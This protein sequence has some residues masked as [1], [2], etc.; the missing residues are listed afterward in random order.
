MIISDKNIYDVFFKELNIT[1]QSDFTFYKAYQTNPKKIKKFGT[2]YI[3]T[4]NTHK[5]KKEYFD[6]V[7]PKEKQTDTLHILVQVDLYSNEDSLSSFVETVKAF[8]FS[9]RVIFSFNRSGIK[10]KEIK[11]SRVLPEEVKGE[12]IYRRGFDVLIE[13][14][15]VHEFNVDYIIE[16]DVSGSPIP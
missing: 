4:Q 12:W 2:V 11:S 15:N 9:D 16:A 14:I 5:N 6:R 10:L 1:F 8:L 13:I 7:N 3:V